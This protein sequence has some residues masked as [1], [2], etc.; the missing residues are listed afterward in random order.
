MSSPVNASHLLGRSRRRLL[1]M[2]MRPLV[3]GV[4]IFGLFVGLVPSALKDVPPES[5]PKSQ[6][7]YSKKA[8]S[9]L[10]LSMQTRSRLKQ[11]QSVT[12][13][14]MTGHKLT[15]AH[16][17]P[18]RSSGQLLSKASPQSNQS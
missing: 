7:H 18:R 4:M 11:H 10:P 17:F 13:A 6:V 2:I 15:T 3:M 1:D 12:V 14:T 9:P 5:S 8:V 16:L